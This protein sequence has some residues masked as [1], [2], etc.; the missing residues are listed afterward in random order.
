MFCSPSTT[1][2][3]RHADGLVRIGT[4][5]SKTNIDKALNSGKISTKSVPEGFRPVPI[6]GIVECHG[7]RGKL[8]VCFDRR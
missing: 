8:R 6:G 4:T 7:R 3:C 1:L 2:I 5:L